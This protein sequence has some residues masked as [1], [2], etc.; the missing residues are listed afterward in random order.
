MLIHTNREPVPDAPAVYFIRPNEANI[1]RIVEDCSKQLY[2]TI[3]LNFL[4]RIDRNLLELLVN[5]LVAINAVSMISKVYDQY[6]DTIALE[7]TLFTL[8]IKDSFM[9]YNETSLTENQIRSFMTRV[10]VGLLST[11]R[12]LGSLP[13]IRCAPGGASE[14]LAKELNSMLKENISAR[15]P[16]QSLFEVIILILHCIYIYYHYV[17]ISIR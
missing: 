1:K 11:I 15:G 12:V 13:I 16:A 8:N 9:M 7:P 2:R 14:M 5:E 4:T 3:Y 6:L 10:A 17:I